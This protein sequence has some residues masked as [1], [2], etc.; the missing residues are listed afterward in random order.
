MK[1]IIS[2]LFI[3][4]LLTGCGSKYTTIDTNKAVE[5]LN[6]ENSVIID[7]REIDEYNSGHIENAINIPL[8]NITDIN[9]DKE[10]K[11]I[12]YCATGVRS[13]EAAKRLTEMGYLN[14]YNLDGG[15]LNWGFELEE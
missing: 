9:Y 8:G 3:C 2:L 15:I 1:K 7:V 10:T 4:I 5:I 11:I 13:G 14:I 12:V 6:E